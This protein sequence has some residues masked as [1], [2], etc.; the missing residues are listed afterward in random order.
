MQ[1]IKRLDEVFLYEMTS[2]DRLVTLQPTPST[3]ALRH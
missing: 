2:L 3:A 1:V